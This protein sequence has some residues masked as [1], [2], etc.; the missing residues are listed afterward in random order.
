MGISANLN[1]KNPPGLLWPEG[2]TRPPERRNFSQLETDL[3]LSAII[4]ALDWDGRHSRFIAQTLAELCLDKN[5]IIFRQE[6][7]ADLLRLP[8]LV[9]GLSR[10]LPQLGELSRL[11]RGPGWAG[12]NPSFRHERN[13]NEEVSPLE[14]L[15]QRL[16][17]LEHYL[18]C[19]QSIG[20][21]LEES[22]DKLQA[23]GL[24]ALQIYFKNL[25]QEATFVSL[26]QTL[27][28]L[29]QQLGQVK[30]LTIGLN[31]DSQLKP[32]SATLL[33][34]NPTRFQGKGN[35]FERLLG[36]WRG[37]EGA[38]RGITPLQRAEQIK[39][40][41][42]EHELY[43]DMQQLLES[44]TSPV[45]QTLEK[46]TRV[47]SDHLAALEPEL[48]FYLG[49]TRLFSEL[50]QSG[51]NFCR[52]EIAP[53][54][55]KI[56][57][58]SGVFNLELV[59]RQRSRHNSSDLAK[60][61]VPNEVGFGPQ[62]LI[63]LLTGPN[64]GGK[65]TYLRAI[66]QAQILGQAGLL[67]PGQFARLSPVD[68]IFT[69]FGGNE[70]SDKNGGRL[71][72]ELNQLNQFFEEGS[73]HSLVLLNEPLSSTDQFSAR[74]LS[75]DLL[76]GLRFLG[77]RTLYVTH[78]LELIDDGLSMNRET[79]GAG[80]ASLVAGVAGASEGSPEAHENNLQP[81]YYISPGLPG[82]L[83]YANRL[84]RQ[85]GMSFDQ[86]EQLLRKRGFSG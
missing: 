84:A 7:L 64:S 22:Q 71:A 63:F 78:L 54:E 74:L 2:V 1:E 76:A 48:A 62:T 66:G 14:K 17:E 35:L 86:I 6:I 19:V 40:Q 59:L 33:S 72:Q 32:E 31:L 43:R 58:I 30:S 61:I 42:S 20:A 3:G 85:F 8:D 4:K 18:T 77:V 65:T 26:S 13:E 79:G 44:V 34:I 60:T 37:G 46:Y 70:V 27:P 28:E 73:P 56:G 29:R 38:S 52:P 45:A 21:V 55:E 5:V 15:T 75:R 53:L 39:S 16:S 41:R 67:V 51:L 10:Y 47:S 50:G 9:G 23:Q 68:N 24:K 83:G 36:D 49:A 80:I 69:H 25:Q 82:E 11:R 81:S 12:L 57:R